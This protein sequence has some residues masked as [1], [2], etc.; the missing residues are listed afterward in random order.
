MKLN[1]II[2]VVIS[3]FSFL[4]ITFAECSYADNVKL[5]NFASNIKAGYDYTQRGETLTYTVEIFNLI[6]DL[7]VE[8]TNSSD[9]KV[10][11][12]NQIEGNTSYNFNSVDS[13]VNH[14]FKVYANSSNCNEQLLRTFILTTP[15]FN[16]YSLRPECKD[17]VDFDLCQKFNYKKINDETFLRELNKKQISNESTEPLEKEDI[18][19]NFNLIT[20]I[21]NN[22]LLIIITGSV[23]IAL[24]IGIFILIKVRNNK[25][26]GF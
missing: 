9:Q 10:L 11:Y 18:D 1:Y 19:S 8:A 3:M 17:N 25:K 6:N 12:F 7:R 13:V 4:N 22:K 21:E 26:I 20:F 24:S 2:I 14:T 5:S 16:K 23:V 15:K